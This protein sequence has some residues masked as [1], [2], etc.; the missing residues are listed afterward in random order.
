MNFKL[1]WFVTI[2][3]TL[4]ANVIIAYFISDY[5]VKGSHMKSSLH[6]VKKDADKPIEKKHMKEL[7]SKVSELQLRIN[8]FEK[9]SISVDKIIQY[10]KKTIATIKKNSHN[11]RLA[12]KKIDEL[13]EKQTIFSH[14]MA[15]INHSKLL[16]DNNVL[17]G[18]EVAQVV[19]RNR[20]VLEA[21]KERMNYERIFQN[22]SRDINWSSMVEEKIESLIV[23]D[24]LGINVHLQEVEC[25]D[26]LCKIKLSHPD[27]VDL[28]DGE[29]MPSIVPQEIRPFF[30]K[31]YFDLV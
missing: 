25:G 22:G 7:L 2:L 3:F 6:L 9:H 18:K 5:V 29:L 31:S 21:E 8:S 24:K 20:H 28:S 17:S 19:L 11:L 13:S 1:S 10:D 14:K 27:T 23:S 26:K 30:K 12:Q 15:T 4:I 16:D